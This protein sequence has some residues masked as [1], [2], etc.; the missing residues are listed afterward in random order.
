[1]DWLI[2]ILPSLCLDQIPNSHSRIEI[3]F[4][5]KMKQTLFSKETTKLLKH[6]QVIYL[7]GLDLL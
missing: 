4:S 3:N 6:H 2:E 1:M 7:Y 5:L